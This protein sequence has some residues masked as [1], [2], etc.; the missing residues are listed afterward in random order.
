MEIHLIVEYSE[1]K[2]W[3]NN[4]VPVKSHEINCHCEVT[5]AAAD[6]PKKSPKPGKSSN[7]KQPI[8]IFCF[9]FL[10]VVFMQRRKHTH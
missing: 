9:Y 2:K 7:D 3:K 4:K 1:E 10:V 5:K 6:W 8:R